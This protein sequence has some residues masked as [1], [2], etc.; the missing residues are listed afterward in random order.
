MEL[1]A[2]VKKINQMI[3]K[4]DSL[5]CLNQNVKYICSII[6]RIFLNQKKE[7]WK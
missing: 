7:K 1:K 3:K 6:L 5:F 2:Y 4:N